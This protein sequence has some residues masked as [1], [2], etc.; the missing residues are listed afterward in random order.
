MERTPLPIV[1]AVAARHFG[2]PG[3]GFSTSC[4][5]GGSVDPGAPAAQRLVPVQAPD[6]EAEPFGTARD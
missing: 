4:T 6:Y 3:L 1:G 5:G 2:D